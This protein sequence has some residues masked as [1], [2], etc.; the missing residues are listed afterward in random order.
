MK[1]ITMCEMISDIIEKF[2]E[3][4]STFFLITIFLI[5]FLQVIFRYI[6]SMAI[7]WGDEAVRYLIIWVVM[8]SGSI[9]VKHDDLVKVN[10]LDNYW[11][12]NF[13]IFR[14]FFYKIF[15]LLFFII[16]VKLSW[17]QALSSQKSKLVGFSSSGVDI[18]LFIP[19]LAIPVGFFLM[20][21]QIFFTFLKNINK[22][23]E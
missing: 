5:L 2:A 9:L 15:F 7:P 22:H 1:I 16:L 18:S 21:V 8:L 23:K 6:F 4:I 20:S 14:D 3:F 13:I 10:F 11:P 12:K 17:N 19:Y